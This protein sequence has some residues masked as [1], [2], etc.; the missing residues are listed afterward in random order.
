MS[1]LYLG[2]LGQLLMNK[3]TAYIALN[4]RDLKKKNLFKTSGLKVSS[5]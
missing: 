1:S 4:T 2:S 5:T 3:H